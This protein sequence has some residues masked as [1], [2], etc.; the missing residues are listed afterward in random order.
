MTLKDYPLHYLDLREIVIMLAIAVACVITC[1]T[2]LYTSADGMA[3]KLTGDVSDEQRKQFKQEKSRS[4][5]ERF[6]ELVFSSTSILLF[7][8]IYFLIDFLGVDIPFRNLWEKYDSILLLFMILVSIMI[9]SL[10]D[11]FLIPLRSMKPGERSSMRLI[12]MIYMLIIFA[13]I[14]FVYDDNNYDSI[15]LYFL[16]L[17]IGRFVYFDTSME[18]VKD[19]LREAFSS[20]PILA[21]VLACSGALAYYGFSSGYLLRSNGVV[22]SLFLAH[23]FL[24]AVIFIEHWGRKLVLR[25]RHFGH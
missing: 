7:V 5:V 1:L 20:L 2:I 24:L 8:G 6:Y 19:V 12:G 15:I 9:N 23:L 10:M 14:K 22:F 21:L 16:T 13:Y 4:L 3:R 17:V 11:N 18:S 25:L